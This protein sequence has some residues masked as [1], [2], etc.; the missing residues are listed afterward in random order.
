MLNPHNKPTEKGIINRSPWPA[1]KKRTM[2]ASDARLIS[3]TPND[4]RRSTWMACAMRLSVSIIYCP[5]GHNLPLVEQHHVM[6]N[7][8]KTGIE[9]LREVFK[10]KLAVEANMRHITNVV[11]LTERLLIHHQLGHDTQPSAWF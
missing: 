10:R 3:P 11:P 4:G 7:D 1:E 5:I 9:V 8:L 2:A 6:A